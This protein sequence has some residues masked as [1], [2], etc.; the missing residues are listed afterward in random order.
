M[1]LRGPL[2]RKVACVLKPRGVCPRHW[3]P[4]CLDAAPSLGEAGVTNFL[5]FLSVRS[6]VAPL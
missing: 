2:G 1:C 5:R 3:M 4:G 6:F